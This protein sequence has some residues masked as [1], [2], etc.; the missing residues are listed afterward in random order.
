M[1]WKHTKG[2]SLVHFNRL[3]QSSLFLYP[4]LCPLLPLLPSFPPFLVS[5][6]CVGR[7][8]TLAVHFFTNV[9]EYL[10]VIIPLSSA[11]RR[12]SVSEA[13]LHSCGNSYCYFKKVVWLSI[14][15]LLGFFGRSALFQ[16]AEDKFQGWCM[17]LKGWREK[18]IFY[19]TL[20]YANIMMVDYCFYRVKPTAVI[21]CSYFPFSLLLWF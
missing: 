15:K 21:L 2:I 8:S 9:S 1:Q 3:N 5:L 11:L 4:P 18:H 12:L 10:I 6:L 14:L 17:K 20:G 13:E 16:M 7:F 19:Q